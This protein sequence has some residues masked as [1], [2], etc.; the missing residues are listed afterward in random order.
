MI[1]KPT[2]LSIHPTAQ[3]EYH[4]HNCYLQAGN[5][6]NR[7]EREPEFFVEL[8]RVAKKI[9]MRDIAISANNVFSQGDK[10]AYYFDKL[11]KET[12]DCGLDFSMTCN[13]DFIHRYLK[14]KDFNGISLVSVS[15]NDFVTPTD[16]KKTDAIEAMRK[17]KGP[18]GEI[19]CNVLLSDSMVKHL[20]NG[21]AEKI[22]E[23]SDTIF[24]LASQPLYVPVQKVYDM[25]GKLKPELMNMISD[26]ILMDSCIRREMGLTG[27]I[28]SKHDFIYVNPYGEIKRCS[29]D[30]RNLFILEKPSDLEYIYG[31]EYPASPL[32][33]CDLV[34]GQYLKEKKAG[35]IVSSISL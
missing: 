34:N 24:L 4:C 33:T 19:N 29:Y 5:D 14:E 17:M 30:Q 20:N 28:C 2:L 6:A 13:H 22:L 35:K 7:Q 1:H 15:I 26:R 8:I 25:I 18:A 32:D 23:V 9:G 21:L 12:L 16:E 3:C 27:G 31:K 10:N 11:K